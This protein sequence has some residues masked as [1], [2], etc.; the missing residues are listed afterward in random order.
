MSLTELNAHYSGLRE[1]RLRNYRFDKEAAASVQLSHRPNE[2]KTFVIVASS[3]SMKLLNIIDK[4]LVTEVEL[5]GPGKSAEY[6]ITPANY[7][8]RLQSSEAMSETCCYV[9]DLIP[10]RKNK[11]LIKGVAWVDRCSFGVVR[12]EGSTSASVSMWVGA[13]HITQEFAEIGGVWLPIRTTSFSTNSLLG[14][15]ELDIRYTHY[16]VRGYDHAVEPRPPD[17]ELP[18]LFGPRLQGDQ[19]DCSQQH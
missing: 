4:L 7:E 18:Q 2:K 13:P 1:Y 9:I 15:S 5:S 14:V 8:A 6:A 19:K 12:L 17:L 10:K 11:Y 16:V 3:G